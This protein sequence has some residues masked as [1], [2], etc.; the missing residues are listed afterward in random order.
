MPKLTKRLVESRRP[1]SADVVI[2]DDEL[3]GFGLRV[4]PSGRKSYLI[5]YRRRSDH[6]SRRLTIGAH[7][8]YTTE[9]A[10]GKARRLLQ[11]VRDGQDPADELRAVR[12]APRVEDLATRYMAEHATVRKKR[13]SAQTDQRN[14]KNHVIPILGPRKV[15]DV[16]RADILDLRN[17]LRGTPGA[18]N[19]VI[20]LLSKMFSLAELWELRPDGTNP[21]RHVERFPERKMKRYLSAAEMDGLG[22]VLAEAERTQTIAHPAITAIRLLIFTGC[23]VSEILTLRWSEVALDRRCLMLSDSKTGS[24]IV[25]LNAPALGVICE[26]RQRSSGPFVIAGSGGGH[27]QNLRRPWMQIRQAAQLE[28]VRIH[29]LRHSFASVA[30]GGGISLPILGGL[31]GHKQPATTA[32]YAHLQ[33]NPLRQAS[34]FIGQQIAAA[35]AGQAGEV[36]ELRAAKRRPVH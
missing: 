28:D 36:V 33:D 25:Y 30:V 24:K 21:C 12:Q 7:G 16:S 15:A 19:R 4:K 14:L 10:R 5:Q 17:R 32:R 6:V 1:E 27:Y 11:A 3:P 26:A 31:L 34:E 22:K 8:I 13:S 29:D 35:M 9:A 20:A 23:R 2:W 18:A